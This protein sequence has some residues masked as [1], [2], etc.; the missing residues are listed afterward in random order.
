MR[1]TGLFYAELMLLTCSSTTKYSSNELNTLFYLQPKQLGPFMLSRTRGPIGFDRRRTGR[2]HWMT[3]KGSIPRQ[4]NGRPGGSRDTSIG[5]DGGIFIGGICKGG[6][7]KGVLGF[8]VNLRM[9]MMGVLGRCRCLVGHIVPQCMR[10][11]K[12]T[13]GRALHW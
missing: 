8:G 12:V 10:G 1:T 13:H 7:E 11:R 3:T 4:R 2:R 5:K 6:L 9:M